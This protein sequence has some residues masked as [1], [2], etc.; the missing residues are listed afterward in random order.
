MPE[1]DTQQLVQSQ[2]N[3]DQSAG[4]PHHFPDPLPPQARQQV[5]L[6]RD[7]LAGI[8]G[9]GNL[10]MPGPRYGKS[11]IE[12]VRTAN[13]TTIADLSTISGLSP[14]LKQEII[15]LM[16]QELRAAGRIKPSI[17][18]VPEEL[19]RR[20]YRKWLSDDA[21]QLQA[22]ARYR[23]LTTAGKAVPEAATAF[24]VARLYEELQQERKAQM[25]DVARPQQPTAVAEPEQT[26]Q[27]LTEKKLAAI[28]SLSPEVQKAVA[29]VNERIQFMERLIRENQP[30]S[31]LRLGELG[32]QIYR[33]LSISEAAE[34]L[35]TEIRDP[36]RKIEVATIL[37]GNNAAI[38]STKTMLSYRPFALVLN[39]GRRINAGKYTPYGFISADRAAF[40]LEDAGTDLTEVRVSLVSEI[41]AEGGNV[42]FDRSPYRHA[43]SYLTDALP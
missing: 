35:K 33:G 2:S 34:R 43:Q 21:A 22:D 16:E 5:G 6:I 4:S 32:S 12:A 41:I 26:Q 20:A 3:P 36:R 31:L 37:S 23:E 17:K 25:E 19:V 13:I 40:N 1:P 39:S 28:D 14:R 24:D 29:G 11:D 9:I 15:D 10:E 30:H 8:V 38:A 42:V 27:Q 18:D 7:Q